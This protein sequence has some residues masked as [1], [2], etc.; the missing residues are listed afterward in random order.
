MMALVFNKNIYFKSFMVPA[1]EQ[2]VNKCYTFSSTVK[3]YDVYERHNTE[4]SVLPQEI[5]YTLLKVKNL[6]DN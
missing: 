1:I 4:N 2:A 3:M 6:K 5:K